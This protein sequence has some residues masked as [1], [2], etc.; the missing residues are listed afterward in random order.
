MPII[1]PVIRPPA[2]A[3]S[4]LLQVTVGCSSNQCTFCAAYYN[5]PF[6]LKPRDEILSD[7][8]QEARRYPGTRRIFL[9]DGDALAM[10]DA[11]LVPIL[12]KLQQSFPDL[13]RV[14]SYANGYNITRRTDEELSG[15]A[16]NWLKLIYVGL[17]SGSQAILDDCK[18]TSTAQEMVTAVQRCAAA[19]IKAS[20]IVLLGLG[21]KLNSHRHVQDTIVALNAMQPRYL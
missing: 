21:G 12:E 16:Q 7:I 20:V 14:A 5:K 2:E 19:G 6:R 1:E 11:Q 13:S 15:L 10:P 18:K 4:F 9:L 3:D 17:E 8:E